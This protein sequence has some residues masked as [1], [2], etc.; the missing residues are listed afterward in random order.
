MLC[1]GEGG[2]IDSVVVDDGS[3][4]R[5]SA[6]QESTAE[7]LGHCDEQG[8]SS[9][10]A[11]CKQAVANPRRLPRQEEVSAAQ[12][13]VESPESGDQRQPVP[14]RK[15]ECVE[16]F[17]AEVRVKQIDLFLGNRPVQGR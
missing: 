2:Q 3:I 4:G 10:E 16:T 7:E 9:P 13:G 1:R 15:G 5:I 6:L 8:S 11:V 17:D 14:E 12:G